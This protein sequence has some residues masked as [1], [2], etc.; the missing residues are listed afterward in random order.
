MRIALHG[1]RDG[2][3]ESAIIR[4]L[5]DQ[6]VEPGLAVY[7]V[8]RSQQVLQEWQEEAQQQAVPPEPALTTPPDNR[9]RATPASGSQNHGASARGMGVGQT[10]SGARPWKR[11]AKWIYG[12][13]TVAAFVVGFIIYGNYEDS[14]NYSRGHE[15]YRQAD[16]ATA[17]ERYERILNAS[18]LYKANY[19][20]FAQ[21]EKD[22][23]IPFDAAARKQ[24][25]GDLPGAIIEYQKYIHRF[26]ASPL[27]AVAR[28]RIG[29]QF[30][31]AQTEAL[32]QEPL[33][34]EIDS[35][36]QDDLIPDQD[37]VLPALYPACGQEFEDRNDYEH[38]VQMYERFLTQYQDHYWAPTVE[39][40]LARSIV[41]KTTQT[42]AGE[43]PA[44]P[45][46]GNAPEGSTVVSIQND[47]PESMRIIFS[48]TESRVEELPACT[49]CKKFTAVG[50]PECP[51]KG[52]SGEYTLQP[53]EYVVV[54]ESVS[55][56]DVT[57]F[58]GTW[59][60]SNGAE[61]AHCFYIVTSFGP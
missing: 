12:L 3:S 52:P 38:A 6:E 58:K 30:T 9:T 44:P 27:A 14:R 15:A 35:F 53:G 24:Q 16:C 10:N 34:L 48:G 43:L 50:P 45:R 17:I 18:R 22:E 59:Q 23:C 32:A 51:N 7:V 41:A 26:K 56:T 55:D 42:G 29:T 4:Y 60:L 13:G 31:Q 21:A 46:S 20:E 36:V 54:V 61:Y 47:S 49:S 2:Y 19:H 37:V 25:S 33:C 28:E 1:L 8:Q 11:N 5:L 40:A 57:P 39:E